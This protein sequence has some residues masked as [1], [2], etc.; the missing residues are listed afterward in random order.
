MRRARPNRDESVVRGVRGEQDMRA[1]HGGSSRA[2]LA[3]ALALAAACGAQ[4]LAPPDTGA[5]GADDPPPAG[6]WNFRVQ[7]DGKPIG[8]HRFT[9]SPRG[10]RLDVRSE[11][12]FDVKLLGLTVYRYRHQASEQ[13]RAGCLDTLDASTDD[14]GQPSRV[15]AKREGGALVV[16]SPTGSTPLPG[17]V[18]TFAYWNPAM[19][20]QARLLNPQTGRFEPVRFADAGSGTIEVRG[21]PTPARKLRIDAPDRPI[22]LWLSAQGD[23]LGLDSTVAGGRVLS[24][25]LE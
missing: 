25:R 21:R 16:A 5:T 6:A 14:D 8:S 12:R 13:W 11:A 7:L 24:Y 20:Q 9:V 17:C 10:D 4:A 19:Q 22:E 18:M 2:A 15:T 3:A 23:W 1:G